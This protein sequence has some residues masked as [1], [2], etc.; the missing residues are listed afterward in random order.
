MRPRAKQA[1]VDG[2]HGNAANGGDALRIQIFAITEVHDFPQI[3]GKAIDVFPEHHALIAVALGP[4][5]SSVVRAIN[6]SVRLV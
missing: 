5:E 3:K 6:G 2:A 1:H 4:L